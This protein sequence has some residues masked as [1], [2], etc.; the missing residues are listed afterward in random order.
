MECRTI[1]LKLGY[2]TYT[3]N[4]YRIPQDLSVTGPV[5]L[6]QKGELAYGT[7]LPAVARL[8]MPLPPEAPVYVFLKGSRS[9][10]SMYLF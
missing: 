9:R 4:V 2:S 10:R 5:M 1:D 8:D 3:L 7:D 6:W